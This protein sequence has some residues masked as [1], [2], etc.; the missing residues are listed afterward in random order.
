VTVRDLYNP[1]VFVRFYPANDV[2]LDVGAVQKEVVIALARTSVAST[3]GNI[4][5]GCQSKCGG[6]VLDSPGGVECSTLNV[7]QRDPK[8]IMLSYH[9]ERQPHEKGSR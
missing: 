1:R 9:T 8:S 3:F 6:K 5:S 7:K 2:N 4:C